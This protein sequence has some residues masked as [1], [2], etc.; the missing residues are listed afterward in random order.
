MNANVTGR[1]VGS[2][3]SSVYAVTNTSAFGLCPSKVPSVST[4][5]RSTIRPVVA[6]YFSLRRPTVRAWLVLTRSST[7][8]G[9][10]A[11]VSGGAVP[12]LPSSSFVAA[13]SVV[14]MRRPYVVRGPRAGVLRADVAQS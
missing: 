1:L 13:S 7:G 3:P 2:A 14:A 11:T 10:A 6:V 9:S 8:P 5:L 12:F 4:S